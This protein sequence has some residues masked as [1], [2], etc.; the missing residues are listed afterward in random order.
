MD[1][2]PRHVSFEASPKRIDTTRLI[3]VSTR[4]NISTN[5]YDDRRVFYKRQIKLEKQNIAFNPVITCAND[6]KQYKYEMTSCIVNQT[7]AKKTVF[8]KNE[9]NAALNAGHYYAFFKVNGYWY[10]MSA[11]RIAQQP[12]LLHQEGK[13]PASPMTDEQFFDYLNNRCQNVVTYPGT[14]EWRNIKASY[15]LKTEQG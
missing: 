14:F 12:D 9:W 3:L 15:S 4:F 13:I 5:S 1:Q 8:E 10:C 6:G 7:N 11:G 2:P